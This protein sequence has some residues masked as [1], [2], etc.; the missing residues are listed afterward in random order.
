MLIGAELNQIQ[1][2]CFLSQISWGLLTPL[3]SPFKIAYAIYA[4]QVPNKYRKHAV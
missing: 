4:L 2:G 1:L 3:P